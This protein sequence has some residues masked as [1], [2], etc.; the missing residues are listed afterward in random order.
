MKVNIGDICVV[1]GALAGLV[2]VVGMATGEH[3]VRHQ[4]ATVCE[5]QPGALLIASY[6]DPKVEAIVC[7]YQD[8]PAK[9]KVIRKVKAR[10]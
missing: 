5:Q 3:K 10:S 2:F 4:I 7:S 6:Q 1:G 8:A 9:A